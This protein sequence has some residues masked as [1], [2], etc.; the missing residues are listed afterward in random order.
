MRKIA[1]FLIVHAMIFQSCKSQYSHLKDGLYAKLITNKGDIMLSLE[2]EKTP[3]TVGNFIGLAEG[4]L[5]NSAK[6]ED[7]PYYDGIK[8]HRVIKD[9]MIQGG[10]PTGTGSGGP[11]YKFADEIHTDL[12]HDKPGILSMA[13]SGPDTNGSQFFITHKATP[14]LN[15]KHTVFGSVIDSISQSVVDS[16]AQNDAITKVEI[17]RIG[18]KAEKF[19]GVKIFNEALKEF[20]KKQEELKIEQEKEAKKF[21]AQ[22]IKWLKNAKT[23]KSGL[24][25]IILEKGKGKRA[26]KKKNVKVHYTLKLENGKKIDSSYDRKQPIDIKIGVGQVIKGWDEGI[27][28]L[29]EG[30]K[31]MFI[32]PSHLGYGENGAGGVIPPNATLYFEVELLE[33]K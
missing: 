9:F 17:I 27:L 23:T 19:D 14:W 32:V 24:K 3:I 6:E 12:I 1:L 15:G 33:V 4:K 7:V 21:K 8:F 5:K 25:Y 31:A 29:K 2:F 16:I 26:K 22:T 28:L 18:E 13:N 11:G 10:D 20:K 30:S